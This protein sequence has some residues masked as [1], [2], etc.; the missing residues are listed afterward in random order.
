MVILDLEEKL[1]INEKTSHLFPCNTI[2][3]ET[4]KNKGSC[5]EEIMLS[6]PRFKMNKKKKGNFPSKIIYGR[7]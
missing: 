7:K 3:I 5:V 2:D 6:K 1:V 4:I